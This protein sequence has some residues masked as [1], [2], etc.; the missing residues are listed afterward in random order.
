MDD[1]LKR[2]S[3]GDKTTCGLDKF[4]KILEQRFSIII[5]ASQLDKLLIF[6]NQ[7]EESVKSGQVLWNDFFKKFS[8][9]EYA[10]MQ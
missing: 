3:L 1:F 4:R 5:S 2:E 9:I 7:K 10:Y 6:I 8:E